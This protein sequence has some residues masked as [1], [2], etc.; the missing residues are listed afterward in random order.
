L[1]IVFHGRYG[2]AY[3]FASVTRFNPVADREGF[4]VVYP[5]ARTRWNDGRDFVASNMD[6]IIFVR[7]L[8]DHLVCSRHIDPRCIYAVGASSGG[9]FVFRLAC[10]M[11]DKIAAFATV[12]AAMPAALKAR[13]KRPKPASLLMING[14]ADPVVLWNGGRVR[15]RHFWSTGGT[16][17][18][19]PQTVAFWEECNSCQSAVRTQLLPDRG[20]HHPTRVYLSSYLSGVAGAALI[21]IEI[22]GGGHRWPGSSVPPALPRMRSV[23]TATDALNAT[24][25]IWRF[26][27]ERRLVL[28]RANAVSNVIS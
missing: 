9:M 22:E 16:L 1:V 25:F 18:S 17:L 14:T 26:F 5:N 20:Y 6:D 28:S 19:V 24:E 11:A 13:G 10:E 8:I 15:S 7:L 21:L 2:N 23:G 12:S 4:A 3:R 27:H